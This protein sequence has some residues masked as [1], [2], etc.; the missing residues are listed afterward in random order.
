MPNFHKADE[1]YGPKQG[2]T[3]NFLGTFEVCSFLLNVR[4]L[5]FWRSRRVVADNEPLSAIPAIGETVS[6]PD[7]GSRLGEVEDIKTGSF[8]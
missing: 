8:V 1:V 3:M 4:V 2:F 5:L 7:L 6:R